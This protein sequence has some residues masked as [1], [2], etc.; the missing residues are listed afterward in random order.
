MVLSE[1]RDKRTVRETL[2]YL[3]VAERLVPVVTEVTFFNERI[4]RLRNTHT[5]G[6]ISLVTVY[7]PTG[8]SEFS[9]RE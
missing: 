2:T 4:I 3:A 8:V 9:V 1:V 6:V 7:A 5:L